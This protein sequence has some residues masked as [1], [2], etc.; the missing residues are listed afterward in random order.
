[1]TRRCGLIHNVLNQH[2]IGETIS[3]VTHHNKNIIF[4]EWLPL[5]AANLLTYLFQ[6]KIV[7]QVGRAVTTFIIAPG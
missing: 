5:L 7:T 4:R 2:S 1:M 6:F 3:V